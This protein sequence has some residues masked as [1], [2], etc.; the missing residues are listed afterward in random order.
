LYLPA[1]LAKAGKFEDYQIFPESAPLV[2]LP[3][4]KHGQK[5]DQKETLD[6]LWL[7]LDVIDTTGLDTNVANIRHSAYNLNPSLLNDLEE[8]IT[9]GNRAMKRPSLLYRDGNIFSY[10]HAPSYVA[11]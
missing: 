11:M 2:L 6:K 10:C 4:K 3:Y 1:H 5:H 7:D 9:T 8:L